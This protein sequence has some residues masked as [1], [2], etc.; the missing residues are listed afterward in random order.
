MAA[1]SVEMRKGAPVRMSRA[2]TTWVVSG[3]IGLTAFSVGLI[4]SEATTEALPAQPRPAVTVT[5]TQQPSAKPG[6]ESSTSTEPTATTSGPTA[7]RPGN[8]TESPLTGPS[9]VSPPS[10][11]TPG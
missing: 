7:T 11:Q 5:S 4:A 10:A 3:A 6:S 2:N 8:P 9:P 1:T